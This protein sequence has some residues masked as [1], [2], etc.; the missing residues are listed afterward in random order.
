MKISPYNNALG[1]IHASLLIRYHRAI[2]N[3]DPF[4]SG[5][6]EQ[7]APAV[8]SQ[9]TNTNLM[10][11]VLEAVRHLETDLSLKTRFDEVSKERNVRIATKQILVDAERFIDRNQQKIISEIERAYARSI[12]DRGGR[13]STN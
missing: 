12:A 8:V 6:T 11:A 10:E 9:M 7:E 3:P 5:R 13:G 2:H 1:R 4:L